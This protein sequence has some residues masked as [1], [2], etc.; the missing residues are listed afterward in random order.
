MSSEQ[1]GIPLAQMML[2]PMPGPFLAPSKW[3][4]LVDRKS[5]AGGLWS[6][7]TW[8]QVSSL[9]LTN[10]VILHFNTVPC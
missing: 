3:V 9:L 8:V 1:P 7:P 6:Q 10:H 2:A 4:V 5:T